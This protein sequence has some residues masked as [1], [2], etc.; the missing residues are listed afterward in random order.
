M[1]VGW[2]MLFPS[3]AIEAAAA[4]VLLILTWPALKSARSYFASSPRY[5]KTRLE[6]DKLLAP[7]DP[8]N[9]AN[10]AMALMC[11]AVCW[12]GDPTDTEGMLGVADEFLQ[13]I[14][15]NAASM[16]RPD[17]LEKGRIPR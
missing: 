1:S 14:E 11:A 13:Y 9:R 5:A 7:I 3:C 2:R 8:D 17:P 4:V 15:G 10:R 12:R 6:V 16:P